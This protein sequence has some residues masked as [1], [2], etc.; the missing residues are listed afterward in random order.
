MLRWLVVALVLWAGLVAA[1]PYRPAGEGGE[2][3]V[4]LFGFH[5]HLNPTE[6]FASYQP[7]LDYLER[8]LPGVQF[9]LEGA[10]DYVEYEAR[11]LARRYHFALPN[12]VQALLAQRAGYHVIAK[13]FPDDDFRGVLVARKGRVRQLGEL[14]RQ[15]LCFPSETAVA[16]TLLPLYHLHRQGVPVRDL[17]RI[18]TG[19]QVAAILNAYSGDAVA[20]GVSARFYR[21]WVRENPDKAEAMEVLFTT[22][23]SPHNAVV[24]RDD[25][26]QELARRVAAAL[27]G[28]AADP[29]VDA[30]AFK[31]GQHRFELATDAT[32]AP[33]RDFL[34]RYDETIGLPPSIKAVIAR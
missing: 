3:R 4:Y 12:P 29:A 20:C 23:P 7:I 25:V 8:R 9:Q 33:F 13:N 18:Y 1:E 26:P 19:T 17:K 34:R 11:L 27:A 30:G 21:S 16:A 5:P 22:E 6:L 2:A 15:P 32:Y 28:M 24:V 14:A 10:R 31:L